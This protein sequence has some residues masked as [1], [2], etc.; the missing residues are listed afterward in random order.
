MM[1][2]ESASANFMVTKILILRSCSL[3]SSAFCVLLT[4]H[5]H[6]IQVE[7]HTKLTRHKNASKQQESGSG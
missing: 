2:E 1:C 6:F 3:I 7:S 4:P 5:V